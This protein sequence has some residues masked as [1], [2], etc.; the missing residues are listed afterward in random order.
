MNK[1]NIL[2]LLCVISSA[3]TWLFA[4][5]STIDYLAFSGDNLLKG[6][7][8]T[9]FTGLFLHSDVTH[10]FGNMMF[11]YIFGN[12]IEKELNQKW[13]LI[14][15]FT[16]GAVS[17]L[18]STQFYDPTVYMIGASAAIFTLTAIVMLLKPLKFSFFF[19][20]PLGL[21]A[22]IYFAF[23]LLAV[24][25]GAQGN[26]SY[27]GHIIGFVV[28]VPFGLASSK[29]WH[30]NLLITIFLFGFYLLIIWFLLPAILNLI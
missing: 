14:P 29:D 16:G 27:V 17:F 19:L 5:E 25:L 23:N 26:I 21:V 22:V 8:W 20:M 4:N 10:L 15:F 30:K 1:T 11:F 9:L 12:T 7:L 18:L 2:I 28:G 3:L 13:V 6:R 24:N